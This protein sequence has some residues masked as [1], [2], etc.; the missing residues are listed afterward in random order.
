MNLKDCRP[1]I[2]FTPAYGWLNDPNG[3]VYH[4]GI[5]ELYYQSNP[6]ALYWENISWGHARSGDLLHWEDLGTVMVPDETGMMF[7][8]SGIQSRPGDAGEEEA[9][10]CF[11]YTAAGDDPSGEEIL[12]GLRRPH[13]TIRLAKSR[14]GGNTLVKGGGEI[15]KP[16]APDNRDPKIFHHEE[17]GAYIIV[18]WLKGNTF[19]IY[20]S[21]DLGFFELSS[22]VELEGGFECPDLF[23]LPA[24]DE[25]GRPAA[26]SP[27]VFWAG[28]GSYYIG[29]FDGYTFTETEPRKRSSMSQLPYAAQ[30][31]SGDPKGR[32]ISISWLRTKTIRGVSTGAMSL[33]WELSLQKTPM[34]FHL[35]RTLPSEIIRAA[36]AVPVS[37]GEAL[38]PCDGAVLLRTMLCE[39]LALCFIN[40][41]GE[42]FFSVRKEKSQLFIASRDVGEYI[43]VYGQEKASE[44]RLIYDR[45]ILE[46]TFTGGL[47]YTVL[48]FTELRSEKISRIMLSSGDA[49]TELLLIPGNAGP[50]PGST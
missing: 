3:L 38:L 25:G 21:E 37:D 1:L 39:G 15:L 29:E 18:L 14:D 27:W 8:G 19:G 48:D 11:P 35:R 46:M 41:S 33:P 44:L 31:F 5:Y 6:D 12:P 28:D 32:V 36:Q 50:G 23:R 2:H 17:S 20:R 42:E 45:G 40:A 7:S 4:D 16:Y 10:L 43:R 9:C 13:F 49:D 26:G 24:V 30:T 47:F 34:G 22:T